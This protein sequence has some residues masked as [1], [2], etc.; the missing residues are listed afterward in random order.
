MKGARVKRL[1]KFNKCFMR[2]QFM[3][4][5]GWIRIVEAFTAILIVSGVVLLIVGNQSMKKP[6]TS[7]VI[8]NSET[9]ILNA[10]QLNNTLRAEIL[11]TT[12]T[13]EW[14]SFSSAAP[15]TQ[16]YVNE[17][18]PNSLDCA[19]QICNQGD[20]CLFSAN[21]SKNIYAESVTISSTLSEF[22]PR[23]LKLFCW[24]K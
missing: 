15:K 1:T 9:A 21:E 16:G 4:K 22:N 7:T 6:D 20:A 17:Q 11:S 18:K 12:G 3:E 19:A 10:I 13:V 23:V 8:I 5:R 2:F 24:A 14:G